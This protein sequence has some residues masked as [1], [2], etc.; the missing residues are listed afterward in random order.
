MSRFYG[1]LCIF[2]R[3]AITLCIGPHSSSYILQIIYVISE[4]N[5]LLPPYPPYLKNVTALLCEMQNF[6]NRLKVMLHSS[7]HRW[8]WKE[9]LE[10]QASN[11][12]ASVQSDHLLHGYML[13]VFFST[14][15][16]HHPPHCAEIQPMSQQ[17]TF[18][19]HPYRTRYALLQHGR[20]AGI[21]WVEVRSGLLAGHMSGLM[22]WTLKF[23]T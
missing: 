14:D 23:F 19:T 1:S 17:D 9:Q 10:C 3:A 5:N 11:V 22:N 2:I 7:K 16:L 12:T 8:L 15:Q 18:A 21:Y 20:D 4:E 6:F 13:P